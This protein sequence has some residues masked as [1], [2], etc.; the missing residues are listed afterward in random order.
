MHV[1]GL[2]V[3]IFDVMFLIA[4]GRIYLVLTSLVYENIINQLYIPNVLLF[5]PILLNYN[6]LNI[7]FKSLMEL[8]K[9]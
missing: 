9:C 2:V 8:L 3:N 5:R 7:L 6:I 4:I 1:Y